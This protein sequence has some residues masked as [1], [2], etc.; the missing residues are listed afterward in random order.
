M[1][2]AE[3]QLYDSLPDEEELRDLIKKEAEGKVWTTL[4]GKRLDITTM[5]ESHIRNCIAMLKRNDYNDMYLPWIV[6]FEEELQRR[7]KEG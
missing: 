6:T 1:S 4:L 5:E 7:I 2:Y 3:E